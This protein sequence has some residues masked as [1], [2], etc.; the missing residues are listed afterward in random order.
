MLQEDF[1]NQVT[2]L[3]SLYSTTKLLYHPI[4]QESTNQ[5]AEEGEEEVCMI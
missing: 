4:E 1:S 2:Y 5:E 3:L